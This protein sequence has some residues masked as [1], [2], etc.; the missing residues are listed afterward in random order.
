MY[1]CMYV[2]VSM[3]EYV[4]EYVCVCEYVSMCVCVLILY[5]Y[6]RCGWFKLCEMTL[7][8]RL[9]CYSRSTTNRITNLYLQ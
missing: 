5:M 6:V 8:T 1:V 7:L 3:C 4:C 9:L 2:C